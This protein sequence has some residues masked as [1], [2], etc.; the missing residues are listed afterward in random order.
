MTMKLEESFSKDDF[1]RNR[2]FFRLFQYRGIRSCIRIKENIYKIITDTD[3]LILK[4]T[5]DIRSVQ[6]SIILNQLL[7][8]NGFTHGL[9]YMELSNGIYYIFEG[10]L[11]WTLTKY[12]PPKRSFSFLREEDRQDGIKLLKSFHLHSGK[13][14]SV[15]SHFLTRENI[16]GKWEERL[17]KFEKNLPIL[18]QWFN[19]SAISEIVYYSKVSLE[20]LKKFDFSAGESDEVVLHGDVASHNFVK[21]MDDKTYLI[22]YD[23]ISIGEAM[24]DDVQYASRILPFIKW[25]MKKFF[26]IPFFRQYLQHPRFWNALSFPADI[27]REGNRFSETQQNHSMPKIYPNLS[28][29]ISSWKH[30]KQFLT[31][32]HNML[33]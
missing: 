18:S 22:D 19:T 23:L 11:I 33:Q 16:L 21:G 5:G 9:E 31:N 27:L 24:W 30:R 17:E 4:G 1:T 10:I 20:H 32:Y 7:Q 8:Q 12:I 6:S 15:L 26:Q 29:F 14:T 28:F 25:D 2:L 3:T 13:H